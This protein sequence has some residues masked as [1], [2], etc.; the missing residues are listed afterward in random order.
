MQ[1]SETSAIHTASH[2]KSHDKSLNRTARHALQVLLMLGLPWLAGQQAIASGNLLINPGAESGPASDVGDA[3]DNVPGWTVVDG[4]TVVTY[5][6]VF[7]GPDVVSPGPASRGLNY[8]AGGPS[9]ALSTATQTIDLSGFQSF[10]ATHPL[11]FTLSGWFGGFSSQNDNAVLSVSFRDAQNNELEF[12]STS[13]V[14]AAARGSETGLIFSSSGFTAASNVN[15]SPRSAVVTLTMTRLDGSYNDG[16]ADNLAFTIDDMTAA[17][18]E[19]GSAALWLVGLAA[20]GWRAQV[21][22]RQR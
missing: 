17:V 8:F 4:F 6:D 1:P 16:Y 20:I 10:F 11:A 12:A 7:G 18:P 9:N 15:L 19:P 14:D 3:V 22:P 2:D 13:L 21:R 5:N